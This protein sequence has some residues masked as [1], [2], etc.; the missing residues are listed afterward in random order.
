MSFLATEEDK[1]ILSE[2]FAFIAACGSETS[3]VSVDTTD[4]N[5]GLDD[6]PFLDDLIDS[7]SLELLNVSDINEQDSTSSV[8]PAVKA[9]PQKP[10]K[11]STKKRRV[12]SAETSSTGLQ[13]RKRAELAS[14][15]EQVE[16]LQGVLDQLKRAGPLALP[17]SKDG[18]DTFESDRGTQWH[19][20][21][22]EQYRLR[23]QAEKVNR[24]LKAIM[25]NHI[26][27]RESLGGVLQ[28]RSVLYGMDYLMNDNA[29]RCSA[30][31]HGANHVDAWMAR[32]ENTTEHLRLLSRSRFETNQHLVLV[33]NSVQC[34]YDERRKTKIIEFETTTP[35][36]WS[37]QEASS[38]L[39]TDF[40]SDRILGNKPD[41]L[42]KKVVLTM[43]SRKGTIAAEKLHFLRKYQNEDEMVLTWADI[44]VLPTKRELQFRTEGIIVLSP[45]TT[46]PDQTT[47]RSFLKL[48]LDTN[49]ID[50]QLRPEDVAYAQD[51]V[52]GAM[53]MKLRLYW[54]SFQN[55]LI[56]GATRT[57][58][59]C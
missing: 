57:P 49:D 10:K 56:E 5:S 13:R 17:L 41:T 8:A 44:M 53:T 19:S 58:Y 26:K 35:L 59:T 38:F 24:Q 2:A 23:L 9:K 3:S 46:K 34:K 39:W 15:R 33:N 4:D 20:H 47:C 14:L 42:I 43:P 45:S 54:Q 36:N 32:L 28:K 21:A 51:I 29:P 27:V 12:R 50:Y 37:L 18:V 30:V 40:Q 55:M 7:N 22:V 31:L 48:Y 52:L 6:V 11:K 16:E 1:T 25:K